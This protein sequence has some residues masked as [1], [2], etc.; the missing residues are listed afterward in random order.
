[1]L[2]ATNTQ[3]PPV[4]AGGF[5][6]KKYAAGL[7]MLVPAAPASNWAR[8]PQLLDLSPGFF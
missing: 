7:E 2:A 4:H 8:N 6:L 3:G 1:M 5:R